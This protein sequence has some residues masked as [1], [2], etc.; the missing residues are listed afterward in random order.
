M[1][2]PVLVASTDGVGT[3]VE[4]AGRLRAR[5]DTTSS[6]TASG[7]SSCRV[8][9]PSSSSTTWLRARG[10]GG[11]DG[12]RHGRGVKRRM[13]PPRRGDGRDAGRSRGALDV[14]GDRVLPS[15]RPCSPLRRGCGR[16]SSASHRAA[17]HER[18]LLRRAFDWAPDGR[19]P[20]RPGPLGAALLEPHRNYLGVLGDAVAS[21]RAKAL[22]HI[23][24]GGL[25]ENVRGCYPRAWP[26]GSICSWPVPPLFELVRE[27]RRAWTTPSCT[28]R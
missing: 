2:D 12:D 24:G 14:A 28:A 11:R 1:E 18:V 6:T 22:A 25:L 8:P 3:K 26:P 4:L 19:R 5:S 7:T 27:R 15:E 21:G 20:G 17:P 10:S 13:R 9:V 23:T 16:R